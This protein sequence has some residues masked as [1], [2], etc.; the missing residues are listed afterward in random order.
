MTS[1][2]SEMTSTGSALT[3]RY[4]TLRSR[5]L[6]GSGVGCRLGLALLVREGVVAWME[7][8]SQYPEIVPPARSGS[9]VTD[10]ALPDDRCAETVHL[11]A[12]MILSGLKEHRA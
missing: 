6:T 12:D 5:V 3:E 1:V 10:D 7:G 9:G 4:E 2:A 8:W 11:L